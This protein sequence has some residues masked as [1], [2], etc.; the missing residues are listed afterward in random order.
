MNEALC[1]RGYCHAFLL[2][3]FQLLAEKVQK[4]RIRSAPHCL[5]Q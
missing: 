1:E 2:T 4:K 3:R 5:F